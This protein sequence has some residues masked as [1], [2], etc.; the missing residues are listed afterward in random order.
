MWAFAVP[1]ASQYGPEF[2]RD[3]KGEERV[4]KTQALFLLK[5]WENMSLVSR[6]LIYFQEEALRGL[7]SSQG[8][9]GLYKIWLIYINNLSSFPIF[10]DHISTPESV[11]D[12]EVRY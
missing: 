5:T 7:E 4:L 3:L 2:S 12:T 11:S 9:R 10:T 6:L 8:K 1:G